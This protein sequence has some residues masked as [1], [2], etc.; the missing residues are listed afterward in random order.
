VAVEIQDVG[1]GATTRPARQKLIDEIDLALVW[2][3]DRRGRSLV[4]LVTTLQELTDPGC[5]LR[6]LERS[7]GPDDKE[8]PSTRRH[9]GCVR[10]FERDILRPQMPKASA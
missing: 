9:V 1:S 6:L 10:R 5:G 4:D 7:S 8:R 2:R 3:V